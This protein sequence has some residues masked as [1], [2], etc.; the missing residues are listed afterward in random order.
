MRTVVKSEY[1]PEL[2]EV[3]MERRAPEAPFVLEA[4]D[5]AYVE[6]C[7]RRVEAAFGLEAFPAVPFGAIP[8]RALIRRL[9]VW[10]RTL[11][12]ADAAQVEAHAQLP[13]AIRLLDTVSAFMEERAGRPGP[14]DA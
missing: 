5:A 12:P 13:G 14:A 1:I 10:W 4:A 8:G 2:S 11:E 3:R 6:G 9:I 7:L